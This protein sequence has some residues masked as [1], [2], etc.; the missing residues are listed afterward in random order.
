MVEE[1]SATDLHERLAAG[2]DVQVVD[3]RP[4]EA[5]ESGHIPGADNVP[6]DEFTGEIDARD[7]HDDIVVVCPLGKSSLQAARLLEA[8][9]G[10]PEDARVANLVGGYEDWEYDLEQS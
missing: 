2:E 10:V 6:F 1:I 3:I 8:F 4:R 9:E 7:W 5:Y